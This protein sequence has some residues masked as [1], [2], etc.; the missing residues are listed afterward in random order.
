LIRPGRWSWLGSA[1]AMA[2]GFLVKLTPIILLPVAIRWLGARLSWDALRHEWFQ[3]KSP[4][5][6]LR[7]VLYTLTAAGVIVVAGYWLLGGHTALAFSSFRI[8]SLRPPWQSVWAVVDGYWGYGLVPLDM[9]NLQ[10]LSRTLWESRLPWNWISLGFLALYLWLYTRRYDW[11]R[12]RAAIAFTGVSAIWMFLY[13]KGWSPQFLV[14]I[15]AFLALLMPNLRGIAL[16][17]AL[18]MVNVVESYIY[19]ILLPGE[20]WILVGTVILRTLLLLAVAVEFLSQV[21]P[22]T[23]DARE[24][25]PASPRFPVWISWLLVGAS[26]LF[27]VLGAPRAAQAYGDRRLAEHPCSEAISYLRADGAIVATPTIAMTQLDLWRDFYPWLR[28]DYTLRVVDAYDPND[29]PAAEVL[30]ERLAGYV[31]QGEFWWLYSDGAPYATADPFPAALPF[32]DK[33]NVH[34]VEQRSFG[35]CRLDRVV[36]APDAVSATAQVQGGPIELVATETITPQVGMPLEAVLYWQAVSPVMASY[37]VFTQL[38]DPSG[39]MVAQQDNLPV[40]GLAP[41]DTWKPGAV[42]RDP[43]RL[44]PERGLTTGA[45]RLLVGLY[46]GQGVRAPLVLRDGTTTDALEIGVEVP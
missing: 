4:G 42:V 13:S 31:G 17:L 3:R 9:R 29:R 39:A 1:V 16:A 2:L 15:L 21:W 37:T 27:V 10:G 26:L 20:R 28:S 14:W 23:E 38:F 25:A 5:N 33:P 24:P 45:Y 12:A 11:S 40:N 22:R 36:A 35:P 19:L 34:V 41:T 46:D 7:P 44:I 32:F 18:S 43:Y 8:N 30:S 6:L